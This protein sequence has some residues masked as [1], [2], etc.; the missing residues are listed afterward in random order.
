MRLFVSEIYIP[1]PVVQSFIRK[2]YFIV[3]VE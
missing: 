1:I 2:I 3:F